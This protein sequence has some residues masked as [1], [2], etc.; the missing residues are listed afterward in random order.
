MKKYKAPGI[1]QFLRLTYHEM[2][3][4]LDTGKLITSQRDPESVFRTVHRSV[5]NIIPAYSCTVYLFNPVRSILTRAVSAVSDIGSYRDIRL[6][7]GI[8]IAWHVAKSGK[9]MVV[10]NVTKCKYYSQAVDSPDATD[11][12]CV[13][14]FPLRKDNNHLGSISIINPR[15]DSEKIISILSVIADYTAIAME[16]ADQYIKAKSLSLKDG[17]TGLYNTRFLFGELEDLAGDAIKQGIPFSVIFMDIDNFKSTVDTCGHLNGSQ[18]IQE[19]AMTILDELKKPEFAV[20]YG[21]DEF[22][23]ILPACKKKEAVKRAL[24]IR[25]RMERTVYLANRGLSVSLSASFGVASFPEDTVDTRQLLDLADRALFTMKSSGKNGVQG[26]F[27]ISEG[28]D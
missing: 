23:V 26:I 18:A 19:V 14:S 11:V 22:V 15:K 20:S 28:S 13:L 2:A 17:L 1:G 4:C 6:S 27:E 5:L 24:K 10:R 21:G 8:G 16:N 25:H 7:S 3:Y 9:M 12:K